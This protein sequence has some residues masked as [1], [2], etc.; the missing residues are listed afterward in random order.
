MSQLPAYLCEE[1]MMSIK[2][3]NLG[4]YLSHPV[5]VDDVGVDAGL[6]GEEPIVGD[7]IAE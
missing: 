3:S 4:K 7:R 1:A 5:F 2:R 6:A